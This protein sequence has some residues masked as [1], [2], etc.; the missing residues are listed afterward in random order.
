MRKRTLNAR[1][2]FAFVT[3]LL[4]NMACAQ[5]QM[6]TTPAYEIPIIR[7]DELPELEE[8]CRAF[9]VAQNKEYILVI[10]K[11]KTF[12]LF[13][14]ADYECPEAHKKCKYIKKNG[15][16]S[17]VEMRIENNHQNPQHHEYKVSYIDATATL[18]AMRF[19]IGAEYV[20]CAHPIHPNLRPNQ[21]L[22]APSYYRNH[23]GLE[24]K[25]LKD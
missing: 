3:A 6:I 7:N 4:P 22:R 8:E 17:I 16:A 21:S 1:I 12:K 11:A 23:E 25:H 2:A 20:I 24:I 9:G 14:L 10:G 13:K 5:E 15:G 19:H 18:Q